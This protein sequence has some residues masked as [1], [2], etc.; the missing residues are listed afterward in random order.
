L[1]GSGESQADGQGYGAA[2]EAVRD[3][4][5]PVVVAA[6]LSFVDLP[7]DYP[8]EGQLG[9]DWDWV[10]DL[11]AGQIPFIDSAQTGGQ[12]FAAAVGQVRDSCGRA[13]RVVGVG[14]SQGAMALSL[15]LANLT[16]AD[17]DLLASVDLLSDPMRRP[18]QANAADEA[19]A[20]QGITWFAPDRWTDA[21]VGGP[22]SL[23]PRWRRWCVQGDPVCAAG[24][25]GQASALVLAG[26]ASNWPVHAQA[27]RADDVAS[28]VAAA[29]ASDLGLDG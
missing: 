15:G 17:Q 3:R 20:A 29:I 9:T 27:Y 19:W 22:P 1:R 8:A 11:L 28:Q 24:E 16:P 26:V 25:P 6:G 18:G 2:V 12:A 14:F 13:A 5:Q 10:A 21:I 23:A 4:L 7:V